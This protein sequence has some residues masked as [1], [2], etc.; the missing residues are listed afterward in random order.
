MDKEEIKMMEV[1]RLKSDRAKLI[2]KQR[3]LLDK[4]TTEKRANLNSDEEQ[5][6]QNMETEIRSLERTIRREEE[7]IERER[8]LEVGATVRGSLVPPDEKE[9]SSDAPSHL[10]AY[11]REM[12]GEKISDGE[13]KVLANLS[14]AFWRAMR[15]EG[16]TPE[17]KRDLSVGTPAAGGYLVPTS[18]AKQI[19]LYERAFGAMR[20]VSFAFRTTGGEQLNLPRVTAYGNANWVGE[21]GNRV[22][23]NNA[24]IG[25]VSFYA[26]AAAYTEKVSQELLMDSAFDTEALIARV[27]GQNI[28]VLQ[29]NAF[30]SGDGSSKPTGITNNVTVGANCANN[31]VTA[32]NL[33]DL[34]HSILPAYRVNGSWLMNDTTISFIRKIKTGIAN[35]TTYVWQPGIQLG[36]PDRILGRPVYADPDVASIA[37]SVKCVLFGDFN[38]GYWIRDAGQIYIQRLNELYSQTGQ[39]GFQIWQRVDAKQVDANAIKCMN[40]A[41]S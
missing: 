19:V 27:M 29:N 26:H 41:S 20:Q 32:D 24:T 7:L 21:A 36:D 28:G 22:V 14:N 39:V 2:A 6:Y 31:A 17:E 12:R 37:N 35:D 9:I 8:S 30:V 11:L 10:R 1:E 38:A 4:A 13:R 34:Y 5:T 23:G 25:Q 33:V 3:E 40:C 15:G 16:L 18:M